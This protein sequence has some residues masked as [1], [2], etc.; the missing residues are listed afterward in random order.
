MVDA[1]DLVRQFVAASPAAATA[2]GEEAELGA[3]LAA[4]IAAARAGCPEVDRAPAGFVAHLARHA[5]ELTR[6]L[7]QARAADVWIACACAEGDAQAVA[8]FEARFRGTIDSVLARMRLD[9]ATLDDARQTVRDRLLVA[10]PGQTPRIASYSGRGELA[11]WVRAAATRVALNLLR[12]QPKTTSD[13][14]LLARVPAAGDDPELLMLKAR[15]GDAFRRAFAA[16]LSALELRTRLLL[17]QHYVDG[18]STDDLGA[19]HGVHRVTVLRWLT[20]ARED[21]ARDVERRLCDGLHV[22][23]RELA[24]LMRLVR[25]RIE[26]DLNDLI[27][28]HD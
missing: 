6:D 9:V 17:K 16:A 21:L 2:P 25:S 8:C 26:L 15:Y 11:G 7:W 23:P 1:A 14:E 24:S 28:S 10:A 5:D 19:L 20:A 27:S 3:A 4:A 13:D 22:A 12:A 18:Q